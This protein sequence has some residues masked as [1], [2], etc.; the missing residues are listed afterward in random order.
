MPKTTSFRS[1]W[2]LCLVLTMLA[3]ACATAPYTGR[4][5][6]LLTSEGHEN[7]LGYQAFSQIQK[8]YKVSHDPKLNAMVN[9]VGQRIAAAANRPDY[10]WEFVVFED[11]TP[12][13]FCLPGGKVGIFTGILKYTQDEPGLAVVISHEVAHALVRHAGERMSQAMVAQLGSLG[14]GMAMAG[15]NPYA[16]Q[17]GQELYGLGAT[18]G[19][20]LP[21]SRK[22]ESEADE[23]G[24]ILMAKAG[25]DPEAAVGF[26]ERMMAAGKG[27]PKPPPFLSTHPT[28]QRRIK[29][30]Q[31]L[32]PRIKEKYYRPQ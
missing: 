26:W 32:L 1:I 4:R 8:E 7:T 19:V 23:V 9:R 20:L 27:R 15:Q 18:V 10:R 17:A 21:Y 24:L 2:L 13:A 22:Q 3:S 16:V 6:L 11:D 14:L 25:Y 5:Q 29:D 12:N 30:I 31:R 28:D